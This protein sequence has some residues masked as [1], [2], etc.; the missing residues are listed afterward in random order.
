MLE[1]CYLDHKLQMFSVHTLTSCPSNIYCDNVI[2]D[3]NIIVVVGEIIP[4]CWWKERRFQAWEE[5]WEGRPRTRRCWGRSGARGRPWTG[6]RIPSR[7]WTPRRSELKIQCDNSSTHFLSK[8]LHLHTNCLQTRLLYTTVGL[9][10]SGLP[11][12]GR[13]WSELVGLG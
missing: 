11:T 6:P 12:L 3:F 7:L 4:N 13:L 2:H 5:R 1:G 9:S 8:T 10:T